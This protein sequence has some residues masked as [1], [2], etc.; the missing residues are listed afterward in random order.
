[1]RRSPKLSHQ[2]L[3]LVAVPLVFQVFFVCWLLHSLDVAQE[4][5]DREKQ[6]HDIVRHLNNLHICMMQLAGGMVAYFVSGN[7]NNL[8]HALSA[9]EGVPEELKALEALS[10]NNPHEAKA[11][12]DVKQITAAIDQITNQIRVM[13][14]SGREIDRAH[15]YQLKSIVGQLRDKADVVMFDENEI[16]EAA[17]KLGTDSRDF[18]K[19][20]IL[21]CMFINIALA[22]TLVSYF[23]YATARRMGILMDNVTRLAVGKE[24]NPPI[25]G[26]DEF[27]QLDRIFG[28]MASSLAEASRKERA[29][30]DNV[31]DV[32][33][34]T[35]DSGHLLKVSPSCS[36]LWGYSP[37][38]LLGTNYLEI[39]H[40]DDRAATAATVAQVKAEQAD[41]RI[42][43]R[44]LRK[45]GTM[46]DVLWSAYW[47]KQESS[48]YFVAHDIT[49][50][51][52]AEAL[53][54]EA[55]AKMR[56]I[57]ESMPVGLMVLTNDGNI[58]LANPTM[59]K[60]FATSTDSLQGKH[61]ST[62]FP[63]I[64]ENERQQFLLKLCQKPEGT[65]EERDARKADGTTIPVEISASRF[66][67]FAGERLLLVVLDIRERKEVERLKRDLIAIVSHELKTPLTSIHGFLS[68]LSENVYGPLSDEL[69]G[70]VELAE[71]S[72][73]HLIKL[74]QDLLAVEKLKSGR[75]E[76]KLRTFQF[77]DVLVRANDAVSHLAKEH[78][79]RVEMPKGKVQI[80]ADPDRMTQVMT[81]I[82]SNAI[83]YSP[84]DGTVVVKLEQTGEWLEVRI[85]DQG[86]GIP[87]SARSRIFE[88]FQQVNASEDEKKGGTG[89]GLAICRAIV[90]QHAGTIGVDSEEGK[91]STFWFRIPTTEA[92]R[93]QSEAQD[94]PLGALP[95]TA[96]EPA[97]SQDAQTPVVDAE[98]LKAELT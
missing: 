27:A 19:R 49:E 74:V 64:R 79:V 31:M 12:Q 77:K 58:E 82:L 35:D 50:R 52:Q 41:L 17:P 94:E 56:L 63:E 43:N 66:E 38:D 44:V 8:E 65:T 28:S 21:G 67:T 45:D 46:I 89:L 22:L 14:K 1:M 76:L 48:F 55:E 62:M 57:L 25:G 7:P 73:M 81:N 68:L 29:V 9:K 47:S 39:V 30:V 88:S 4:E 24:L 90:E 83:K 33:C 23:K 93:R 15:V 5:V 97:Q 32:I 26:S 2:G 78:K 34:S 42:E 40:A 53:L 37:D 75:S 61:L 20:I 6:A 3:I 96:A 86:P 70:R 72:V 54:K 85:S 80:E 91:G 59:E 92:A 84:T 98:P 11:V 60:M 13:A 87:Q 69:A 95:A 16:E 18:I 10:A 51:K 71:S 36:K